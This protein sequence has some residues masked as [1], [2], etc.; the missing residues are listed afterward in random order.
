MAR[1]FFGTANAVGRP[2]QTGRGERRSEP[3]AVDRRR[4]D[5]RSTARC[6]NAC[7]RSSTCRAHQVSDG[8]RSVNFVGASPTRRCR[9]MP[10]VKEAV[11]RRVRASSLEFTTLRAQ[12]DESMRLMRATAT[13]AGFFGALALMLATIGLYG[14]MSYSVA[15]RRNE[16]GVRIALGAGRGRESFAWCSATS[17]GSSWSG[18][19]SASRCRPRR[20]GS[21]RHSSTR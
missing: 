9:I 15:R 18:S 16:I 19:C 20:R 2:F 1:K 5:R 17:V 10:A 14:I 12:L 11:A 7:Q 13:V 3:I 4:A 8:R 6:A 21:S